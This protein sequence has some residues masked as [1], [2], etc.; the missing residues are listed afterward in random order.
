MPFLGERGQNVGKIALSSLV[1]TTR[2]AWGWQSCP[3]PAES[4]ADE[5]VTL[6]PGFLGPAA[7]VW[8]PIWSLGLE[9]VGAITENL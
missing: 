1:A 8:P 9:L 2:G 7:K 6:L 5:S 3:V 4:S